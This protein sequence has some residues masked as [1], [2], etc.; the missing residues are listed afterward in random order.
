MNNA[1]NNTIR[2]FIVAPVT[3]FLK[4]FRDEPTFDITEVLRYGEDTVIVNGRLVD[5]NNNPTE[6]FLIAQESSYL[7][8]GTLNRAHPWAHER[9]RR[10]A[11]SIAIDFEGNQHEMTHILPPTIRVKRRRFV[12]NKT[13]PNY[14]T[15]PAPVGYNGYYA[16][17]LKAAGVSL[18]ALTEFRVMYR[19][20]LHT[21]RLASVIYV[22]DNDA[23]RKVFQNAAPV[24]KV[25]DVHRHPLRRARRR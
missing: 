23:N 15:G 20:N 9:Y 11:V 24:Q 13:Y 21:E 12:S 4:S 17:D 2:P 25:G 3:R 18:T 16:H 8:L 7:V 6:C 19:I 22:P 1:A 10:V 14:K 5:A